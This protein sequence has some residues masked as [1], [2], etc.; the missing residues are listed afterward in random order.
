MARKWQEWSHN[1][2]YPSMWDNKRLFVS[3]KLF[4]FPEINSTEDF[5]G[6]RL[7]FRSLK[8]LSATQLAKIGRKHQKWPTELSFLSCRRVQQL[9]RGPS[10]NLFSLNDLNWDCQVWTLS[11][12]VYIA[13][14]ASKLSRVY[15]CPRLSPL[16]HA[17][18]TQDQPA[19]CCILK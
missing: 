14:F 4:H 17:W 11:T 7:V 8:G 16:S 13:F 5:W 9:L 10:T 15:I 12:W 19:V 2:Q 3:S 6:L 1:C 18:T